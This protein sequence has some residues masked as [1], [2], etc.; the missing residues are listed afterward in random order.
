MNI[1]DP[2]AYSFILQDDIYLLAADKQSFQKG[3][4]P[5]PEPAPVQ[6][7]PKPVYKYRGGYK[8]RYLIITHY[9]AADFIT[10]PHLTALE[11]TLKRLGV[12]PDDTAI[13]NMAQHPDAQFEHITDFFKPQKMLVLGQPALPPG[14]RAVDR[15]TPGQLGDVRTLFTFSFDEMM[16]NVNSKKAFWEAMKLF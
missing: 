14:M 7:S 1:E 11:S 16:D 6:E 8:K 2:R 15:N 12:D 4:Q 3:G 10:E 13:F 5:A 9:S